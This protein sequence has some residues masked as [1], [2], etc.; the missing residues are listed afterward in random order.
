MTVRSQCHA[1]AADVSVMTAAIREIRLHGPRPGPGKWQG[2]ADHVTRRRAIAGPATGSSGL[3]GMPSCRCGTC[4]R[5]CLLVHPG[6]DA[7]SASAI[8]R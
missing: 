5:Q 1:A 3:P 8:M 2:P 7:A 6:Q 4:S